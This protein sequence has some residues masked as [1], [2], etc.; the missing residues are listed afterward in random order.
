LRRIQ[1]GDGPRRLAAVRNIITREDFF[2]DF[3]GLGA[4]PLLTS[5][6]A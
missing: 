6:I 5:C 4:A 1:G 2:K 3:E